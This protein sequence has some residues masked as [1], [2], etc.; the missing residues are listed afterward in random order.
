MITVKTWADGTGRWH[1]R[2]TQSADSSVAAESLRGI[3]F[4]AIDGEIKTREEGEECG[5]VVPVSSDGAEH[6]FTERIDEEVD[7]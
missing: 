5:G 4:Y 7:W 3:A 2:V 1:A 6:V